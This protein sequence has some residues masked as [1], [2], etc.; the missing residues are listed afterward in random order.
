M[1]ETLFWFECVQVSADYILQQ[2][3]LYFSLAFQEEHA[4]EAQ[5]KKDDAESENKGEEKKEGE[6]QDENQEG[7]WE[8]TFNGHDDSKPR[9]TICFCFENELA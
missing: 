8:E 4:D 2:L 3:T 9:G 5:E 6:A 1:Q 7:M